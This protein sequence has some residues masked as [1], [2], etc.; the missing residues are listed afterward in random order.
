MQP[1]PDPNH[2]LN[3][4]PWQHSRSR[5]R[6]AIESFLGLAQDELDHP[7][8]PLPFPAAAGHL[9]LAWLRE[10]VRQPAPASLPDP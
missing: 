7:H 3:R 6:Q 9:V 10:R 4:Y 2:P 5:E 1:I 8:A